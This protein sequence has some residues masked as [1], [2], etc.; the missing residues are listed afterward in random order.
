MH[1]QYVKFAFQK[2]LKGYV[3]ESEIM[4]ILSQDNPD[5]ELITQRKQMLR[6]CQPLSSVQK[7]KYEKDKYY[8]ERKLNPDKSWKKKAQEEIRR[9]RKS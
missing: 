2:T 9:M 8:Q 3:E 7:E 1:D 6:Y 5:E 4:K